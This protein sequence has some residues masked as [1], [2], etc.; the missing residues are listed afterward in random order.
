MALKLREMVL[1]LSERLSIREQTAENILNSEN[2][3]FAVCS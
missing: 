3:K 2:I 1:L